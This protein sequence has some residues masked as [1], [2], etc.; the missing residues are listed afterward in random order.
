MPALDELVTLLDLGQIGP[1]RFRC[2][3]IDTD[4]RRTY[5]G[6]LVAPSPLAPGLSAPPDRDVHSLHAYFLRAGTPT[7]AI[8]FAVDVTRDSATFSTFRVVA[9]QEGRTLLSL[10]ASFQ[11]VEDGPEADDVAPTVPDPEE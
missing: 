1:R 6:Q 2:G 4:R 3:P 8:D 5:G 10:E 7:A 9:E 11:A